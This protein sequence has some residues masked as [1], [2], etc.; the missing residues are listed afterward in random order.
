[1]YWIVHTAMAF[2]CKR[3]HTATNRHHH[4][5]QLPGINFADVIT[6]SPLLYSIERCLALKDDRTMPA[7]LIRTRLA[8]IDVTAAKAPPPN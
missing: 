2:W 1:M 4:S 7:S 6:A 8:A 3:I 5:G